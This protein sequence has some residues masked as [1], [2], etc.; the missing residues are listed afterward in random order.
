MFYLTLN[1]FVF[2]FSNDSLRPPIYTIVMSVLALMGFL[3]GL[4]TM[5]VLKFFGITDWLFSAAVSSVSFP[6]FVYFCLGS[7]VVLSALGGGYSKHSLWWSLMTTIAW[8]IV[9]SLC[10]FYGAYRGYLMPRVKAQAKP[11]TIAR[12]I[13]QQPRLMNLCFIMITFGAIQYL[14][15]C[16]EFSAIFSSLWRSKLYMLFGW[17]FIDLIMLVLIISMLSA[18]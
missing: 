6:C 16:L 18:I 8:V 12:T 1:A 15:M 9:N 14:A 7:E 5:R 11:Q 10:C 3:N 2:F 17:L 13:P 4:T